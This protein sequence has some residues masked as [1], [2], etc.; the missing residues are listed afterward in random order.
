MQKIGKLTLKNFKF[1]LGEVSIN[2]DRKNVLLYGE[3]GSGKSSIYWALYTFLQSVFKNDPLQ[4]RKYFDPGH[5]ENLIN[6]FAP[7]AEASS[8]VVE[9]KD[10]TGATTIREISLTSIQTRPGNPDNLVL[11]AALGSDFI[12][13]KILSRVYSYY[14]KEDIDLFDF[15]EHHLLSFIN[16]RQSLT[17][18]GQATGNAN[19]EHWWN[20]IKAGLNP[21]PNMNDA[22]Y[23]AFQGVIADFNTEFNYYLNEISQRTNILLRDKFQADFRIRLDYKNATYNDFNEHNK[24]R[25]KKTIAPKIILSVDLVTPLITDANKR[26]IASPQSFLNEAKLSTMA[27]AMRLAII[28]EKFVAAYPKVLVLDDMLVSMDMSNREFVM[29]IMLEYTSDFQILFFT[30]QRGL[31]EDARKHIENFHA[32]K[33]RLRGVTVEQDIKDEWK[34]HWKVMEMYEGE[35][36]SHIPVPIIQPYESSLQKALKYFKEHIDYNACGNNLR[37]SLEEFFLDFLPHNFI[38]NQTMIAGLIVSARAYFTHVGFDTTPLDK[39]ERYRERS[40]NPSSHFNPRADFF[41]RELQ[42]IFSILEGLKANKNFPLLR[43][44]SL[45]KFEIHTT[46]GKVF[47]YT[48]TILDDICL[49]QKSD[50]SASYFIDT[51]QRAYAM[52]GVTEDNL[53]TRL[54]TNVTNLRTLQVLYDETVAFINQHHTAMVVADM[55]QVFTDINGNTLDSLKQY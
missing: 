6:R 42:D 46:A 16:F 1:F 29:S 3:N 53:T 9:F 21:H 17:I 54:L 50:G 12:D 5:D 4:I 32:E 45:I 14:H 15:F 25:N 35:N 44:D 24:G 28:D 38:N 37:A 48:A 10:D 39:L 41:K 2:F 40:L 26:H 36:A 52:I 47:A 30:H 31:F 27:L 7:A 22:V 55:Y 43:R 18:P 49:Y 19:S 51:D 33:A 8:I 20:Y 13:H 23:I 34:T 11:N